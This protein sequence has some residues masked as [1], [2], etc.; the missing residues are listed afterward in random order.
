MGKSTAVR[1]LVAIAIAALMPSPGQA[2]PSAPEQP[3]G[4]AAPNSPPLP[5]AGEVLNEDQIR[6]KL[7]EEGYSEVTELRLQGPSYEAKATK[8]GRNVNLT[9]DARTGSVRSTY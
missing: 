7:L 1:A 5:S 4:R 9:V 6:Q 8:D 3:S 2:Q